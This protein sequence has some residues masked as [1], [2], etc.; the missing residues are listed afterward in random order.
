MKTPRDYTGKKLLPT[1]QVDLYFQRIEE[2]QRIEDVY[3]AT[4]DPVLL[5]EIE[6]ARERIREVMKFLR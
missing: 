4:G 2:R 5:P 3:Y 1:Q 6:K